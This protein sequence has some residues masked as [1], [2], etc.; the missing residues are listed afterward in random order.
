[1]IKKEQEILIISPIN[2]S[3]GATIANDILK[4]KKLDTVDPSNWDVIGIDEC[5][6]FGGI[7]KNITKQKK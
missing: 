5:H 3:I 7:K 4:I 6:F 1:M 2:P